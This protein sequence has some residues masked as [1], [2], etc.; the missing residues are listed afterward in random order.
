MVFTQAVWWIMLAAAL[1]VGCTAAYL[2]HLNWNEN[3]KAT[4]TSVFLGAAVAF[5]IAVLAGLRASSTADR[6]VSAVVLDA[7]GL[8]VW[9][10]SGDFP[11]PPNELIGHLSGLRSIAQ[12][13]PFSPSDPNSVARQRYAA[14]LLQYHLLKT[15]AGMG[16]EAGVNVQVSRG[17]EEV[18]L[19]SAIRCPLRAVRPEE[20]ENLDRNPFAV[21][22]HEKE[23]LRN[24]PLRIPEHAGVMLG[25]NE[26]PSIVFYR[27]GYFRF[28]V[29]IRSLGDAVG[30]LPKGYE[31]LR[32]HA[33]ECHSMPLL[34]E[35]DAEFEKYTGGSKYTSDVQTW[36]EAVSERFR[37]EAATQRE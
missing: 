7:Q 13:R 33:S 19:R 6:F 37:Q 34:V 17:V 18:T 15:L 8:P 2:A 27:P 14:D 22:E 20:I 12:N 1:V 28:S 5:F 35:L 32:D 26:A 21:M 10:G 11:P 30:I 24:V 4:T 9:F 29:T 23:I 36:V 3:L 31:Y 25:G 16:P